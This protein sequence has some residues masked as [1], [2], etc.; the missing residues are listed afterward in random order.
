MKEFFNEINSIENVSS[1][2]LFSLEGHLVIYESNELLAF[3]KNMVESYVS[4]LNWHEIRE[5]FND[6]VEAEFIF[7]RYRIYI[8]KF[9]QG[10]IAVIM[11]LNAHSDVVK[12][13][14]DILL[15]ELSH[16]KKHKGLG[17]F[18]KFGQ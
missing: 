12:L 5:R 8:R 11:D 1:S 6:I 7:S 10:F 4:S 17:R 15:P 3:S 16:L 2:M 14:I 18:F 9:D 13:H